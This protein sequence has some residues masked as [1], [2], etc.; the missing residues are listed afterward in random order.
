[1][2]RVMSAQVPMISQE[3]PSNRKKEHKGNW[4][5]SRNEVPCIWSTTIGELYFGAPL[6]GAPSIW[7]PDF[8]EHS[9]W[10]TAKGAQAY[11]EPQSKG[12]QAYLEPQSKGAQAYLEPQSKG[13]QAYLEPQ[14][15]RAQGYLE[16]R[17]P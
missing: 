14:S 8:L 4:N 9:V 2:S 12:A 13:A 6:N 16:H 3:Q 10:G 1:M 15:K 11:L 5:G 17:P 7:S